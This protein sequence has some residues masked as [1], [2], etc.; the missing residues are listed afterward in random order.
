MTR[1]LSERLGKDNVSAHHGSLSKESRLEAEQRLKAGRLRA[2]VATASLE[3]G[4]DIG[5]VDLVCQLGSP[6]AIA[7]FLQRVGRA[8]HAV[9]GI[10]R[11][12][13]FPL[14][15][16]ELVECAALLDAVGRG[17][18][19]R[20]IIPHQPLDVLAQQIVAEVA[21]REWDEDGLFALCRRAWPYRALARAEFDAVVHMLAEGFSTRR[22]RRSAYLHRDAVNRRLRPRQGARLTALT[23][24]GAIPDNADYAVILEPTGTFIGTL[25]EDFAVESMAGACSSWATPR[26]ASCVSR[27]G[28]CG[29]RTPRARRPIFHSGWARRRGAAPSFRLRSRACARRSIEG[30]T[31]SA[32]R[33]WPGPATGSGASWP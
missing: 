15:R 30:S 2:L 24:G 27:P 20:L 12:R 16:D 11:G 3:L 33:R 4:I 6:R 10:P 8:N 19:D 13:L 21:S 17:E 29:S 18:L 5:D 31:R 7:V 22:G 32:A 26:T 9:A 23:C 25:N 1:H 28:R 14:S